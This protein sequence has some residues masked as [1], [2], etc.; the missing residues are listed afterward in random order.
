MT[1]NVFKQQNTLPMK[2]TKLASYIANVKS[3]LFCNA[4]EDYKQMFITY[5][6]HNDDIDN[7]IE[8]FERCMQRGMSPHT[9]LT[10]FY[11]HIT[12]NEF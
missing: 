8:Y 10:L 6:Y 5:L 9:A 12:P 3:Q 7:H 2:K 4:S 11:D 1:A